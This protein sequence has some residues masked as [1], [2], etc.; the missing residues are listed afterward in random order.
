MSTQFRSR[1]KTVVDYSANAAATGGCC[2]P[3]GTK[4]TGDNITINECN[5]QNGFYSVLIGG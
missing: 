1:I 4:L 2:L 3:D 5:R